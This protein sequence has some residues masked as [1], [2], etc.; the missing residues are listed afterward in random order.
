[1]KILLIDKLFAKSAVPTSVN[2]FKLNQMEVIS[3]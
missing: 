3:V 1:M 2:Y